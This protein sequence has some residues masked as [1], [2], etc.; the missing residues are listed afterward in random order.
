M[1][2]ASA[3]PVET[4]SGSPTRPYPT[5]AGS[6]LRRSWSVSS[7]V[8]RLWLEDPG[9]R[10]AEVPPALGIHRS[11]SPVRRGTR[12]PRPPRAGATR[13]RP[14]RRRLARGERH[15]DTGRIVTGGRR[16]RNSRASCAQRYTRIAS[17]LEPGQCRAGCG[18]PRRARVRLG[19]GAERV[20]RRW[21]CPRYEPA[22]RFGPTRRSSDVRIWRGRLRWVTPTC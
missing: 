13:R 17:G 6:R 1:R 14:V 7:E 22:C 18:A 15:G 3:Q 19:G 21:A 10:G 4:A 9:R 12:C 20:L 5:R 11:P 2:S 16:G 8:F